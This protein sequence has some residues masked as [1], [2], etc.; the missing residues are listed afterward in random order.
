ML[1]AGSPAIC[2]SIGPSTENSPSTISS[3]P[4]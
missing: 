1:A 4:A 3:T 2:G